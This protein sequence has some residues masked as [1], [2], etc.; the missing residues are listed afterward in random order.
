MKHVPRPDL[1]RRVSDGL[2]E[3]PAVVLIG[4]RQVGKSTLARQIADVQPGQGALVLD[5]EDERDRRRLD[6][7]AAFLGDRIGQ[8]TV[9]DEVHRAPRLFESLRGLIDEARRRG[10]RHGQ[11][12]LL[13]SASLDL[14]Q[15]T[16]ET[17]AGRVRYLEQGPITPQEAAAAGIERK[18]LWVRGGFPES[19][20]APTDI[21]SLRW[22]RDFIRS[23]LERDI[24]MFAPRLPGALIGRLWRMLATEQG[25]L[26]NAARLASGLGVT[27]T[28]VDRYID[29]LSDLL[30]VR[31]L[32]PWSANLGKR[33]VR[34]PKIYVRD[35]GIVHG[36]LEIG[37]HTQ[38]LGHPVAGS[39]WE[40]FVIDA[41]VDAVG[42]HARPYFYRTS[43]G[44]EIDLI[45]E[46]AGAAR[47][48]IEIKLSSAPSVPRGFHQACDD[49][50]IEHRFLVYGGTDPAWP[51]SNRITAIGLAEAID[52]V[53]A[54]TADPFGRTF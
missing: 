25:G 50:G 7:A 54:L 37:D 48:G 35:S 3:A 18:Q 39:S 36:L 51:M 31:R 11:F 23:Y 45:F 28:T 21:E 12:L 4:A 34:S 19:L 6:D 16:S 14:I 5:L 32:Q 15:A 49:L 41:L 1:V 27:R 40:G 43:N 52:R 17:L 44:A 2:G 30:L 20:L 9:I 38:L 53:R 42:D 26:L 46:M 10:Q 24:P 22:R 13:G 33:L 47:I 8:L 29:L